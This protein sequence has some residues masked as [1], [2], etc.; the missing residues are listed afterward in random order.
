MRRLIPLALLLGASALPAQS[1]RDASVRT[2]PQFY[3]YT[4]KSPLNE[5]ISELAIPV[6]VMVPVMTGLTV[7]VGTAFAMVS[8]EQTQLIGGTPTKVTSELSGLTDTQLRLNYAV[9]QDFIVLTAG[10]NVPSGSA[11]VQP[12]EVTAATR[13]GSDFLTFPVSGFGSG[14]GF[15]GGFALARPMGEWNF[16][17]GASVRQSSEYEPF[18]DGT[19]NPLK[20]TPGPE[21]RARLGLDHALGTGRM[22]FGLTYS[23]FGDDKAN[24]TTFNTGSRFIGQ[25]AMN[26]SLGSS[27]VDYS[28]VVWNLFRA[29]G[30]AIGGGTSPSGNIA[31]A[32]MTFGIRG[33]RDIGF[34]PG[35]ETRVWTEQGSKTSFLGTLGMR[36][37]V[38]RGRWAI[39]PGAGFSFGTMESATVSGFKATLGM[40]FGS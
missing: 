10:V 11:T 22:S 31:N 39:V 30:T 14:L 37:Y 15:T 23:K 21:Y 20:F 2:G 3:S 12:E 25:F 32:S 8:H 13:I 33:P 28:L 27:E 40:R 18:L 29:S 5:K 6:F 4:L 7:D 36:A 35:V 24:A 26:N 34:E 16:G 19:G 38:D 1:F 17:F 9:G